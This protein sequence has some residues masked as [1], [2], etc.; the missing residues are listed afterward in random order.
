[1]YGGHVGLRTPACCRLAVLYLTLFSGLLTLLYANHPPAL[2]Q[3]PTPTPTCTQPNDVDIAFAFCDAAHDDLAGDYSS[4]LKDVSTDGYIPPVILKAIGWFETQDSPIGGWAQC[5]SGYPYSS[6]SGCDWGIMQIYSGMNCDDPGSQFNTET[7][8]QVKYDYRYN[9][10]MG[11]YIL[12]KWKWDWHQQNGHII[13]DGDPHI[14]EHW[15]Y[16]VWAYNG[17]TVGNSSNFPQWD[18]CQYPNSDVGCAYVDKIWWRAAYPPSRGG[19]TLWSAVNLTRPAK[20]LF[21]RYEWQWS[22][23]NWQIAD[24]TPVHRDSCRTCLPVVLKCWPDILFFETFNPIHEGWVFYSDAPGGSLGEY[25]H[26]DSRGRTDNHS[27]FISEGSHDYTSGARITVAVPSDGTPL[28]LSYWHKV[29][30][31]YGRFE[32]FI[33]GNR[34]NLDAAGD[35]WRQNT[36]AINPDYTY[37]GQITLDF[38]VASAV[39]HTVSVLFD[40]IE[41]RIS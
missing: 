13:G 29:V 1:M 12:K 2:A 15:Y 11:A 35:N 20:T 5:V 21:P 7:Q 3:T 34:V 22:S 18:A 41:I 10:A 36:M 28:T 19:R 17:W 27:L 24:P 4:P 14:A 32:V 9:I 8:Q 37:D 16:A 40:D 38:R 31:T 30:G 6:A 25:V 39:I 33:D 23:W 26:L